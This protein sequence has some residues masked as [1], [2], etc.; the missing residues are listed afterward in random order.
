MYCEIVLLLLNTHM[1]CVYLIVEGQLMDGNK[2]F[3]FTLCLK[4]KLMRV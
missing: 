1:F 3:Y 2:L 4:G